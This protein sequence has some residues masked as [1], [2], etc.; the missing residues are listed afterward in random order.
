[1]S[2]D[3]PSDA[4]TEVFLRDL[5]FLIATDE[6]VQDDFSHLCE[7]LE[8]SG[9]S[10]VE[11][12]PSE[13]PTDAGM[14]LSGLAL[15]QQAPPSPYTTSSE[16]SAAS[17]DTSLPRV[18]A[19]NRF[20]YRQR[21]ELKALREQVQVLKSQLAAEASTRKTAVSRKREA[22]PWEMA[23][24]DELLERNRAV[25]ENKHLKDAVEE[26][27]TF[28]EQMKKMLMKK[29]RL[30]AASIDP[31]S[32]A[33]Q[34]YKLAATTSLRVASIHAI[35]D[36]Q[37]R[38]LQNAFIQAGLFQSPALRIADAAPRV[39]GDGTILME[40]KRRFTLPVPLHVGGP[41]AWRVMQS[42]APVCT[43]A[44]YTTEDIDSRTVYQTFSQHVRGLDL[45]SNAIRKYY[46]ADTRHVIV[47][48]NVLEDALLPH[49]SRG[50]V[51]N[52]WGWMVGEPVAE[53]KSI[54][55]LTFLIQVLLDTPK[56]YNQEATLAEINHAIARFGFLQ[57][58]QEGEDTSVEVNSPVTAAFM[59]N[60]K[61]FELALKTGL[62]N[63][64]EEYH[65]ALSTAKE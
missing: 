57:L 60:G 26:Q 17:K 40:F 34:E 1:M 52:E 5:Q 43:D 62:T 33:W 8:D 22:S 15:V 2:A 56:D 30:M 14:D 42:Y 38:R 16:P 11:S 41:A 4:E 59:G 61:R 55:S 49:M 24:R 65:R 37:F 36:R 46:P 18:G 54:T 27:S 32:E 20:Q 64:I 23:A 63:A 12:T 9:A 3:G 51:N 35:A 31:T 45:H 47:W 25:A 39:Q 7:L 28:V 48:R 10:E 21:Q 58:G 13:A 19:R 50:S 53:N 6:Q 29:P 44:H